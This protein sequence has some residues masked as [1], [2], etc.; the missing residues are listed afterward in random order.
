MSRAGRAGPVDAPPRWFDLLALAGPIGIA[1]VG[2]FGLLLAVLGVYTGWLA[3]ALG[4]PVAAA[5]LL[6][7]HRV[8]PS[9]SPGSLRT[10]HGRAAIAAVVLAVGYLVFDRLRDTLAEAV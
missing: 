4:V 5:M 2:S 6:G 1:T 3:L 8:L 10:G 9:G 7:A